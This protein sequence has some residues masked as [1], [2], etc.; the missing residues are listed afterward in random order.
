MNIP[1]KW[2]GRGLTA[3]VLLVAAVAVF[4]QA[5][6]ASTSTV[7]VKAF[8]YRLQAR[9]LAE[10]VYVVEGANADFA[11]A[12]GCNIINTGFIVGSDGVLVVN[13]GPSRRYGEQLRTLIRRVSDLPVKQV[14][15]LNQHPDYFLGNQGF[16]DVPR[17]AT[18]STRGGMQREARAYEDNLYRICGDWMTGT[19]ALLPNQ[20]LQPG[21]MQFGG[22][23]IELL[24]FS[25]HT[26][27]DL[28]LVDRRSG[29]AFA[30]G[31]VF[32]ER[33]PTTPHADIPRWLNS[34]EKI[35]S[36]KADVIVPSHGPVLLDREAMA[37]TQAYL[38][39][40]DSRLQSA[41]AQGQDINDLLRDGLPLIYRKW[42]A[43]GSE[44]TRTLTHLF[45]RYE[46]QALHP[47]KACN[48]SN[49][50]ANSA[51][52]PQ[53]G[54]TVTGCEGMAQSMSVESPNHRGN[55]R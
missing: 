33:V 28:V 52:L 49:S 37:Q 43:A 8:D 42:A 44:F 4:A 41:A 1:P 54:T 16:A 17:L 26:A 11:P 38:Q 6:P 50:G 45:A 34:L 55:P 46:S 3:F 39:W 5:G 53:N 35:R 20:N 12:N 2:V 22:R 32:R 27:S 21:A 9:A 23:E 19:E 51:A 7:D 47:T 25:G 40:L 48:G 24:E 29:V 15:H 13:T 31:L 14:I 30:G 36:L 18:A 10:G